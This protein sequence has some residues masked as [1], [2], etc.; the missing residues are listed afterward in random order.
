MSEPEFKML[1]VG[2]PGPLR[3]ALSSLLATIGRFAHPLTAD[4]GLLAL[5]MVREIHPTCV[6]LAS[7]L[8]NSEALE[9]VRQIKQEQPTV[10]LL[11]LADSEQQRR[12]L[13]AVGA[14]R[15]LPTGVPLSQLSATLREIT[16]SVPPKK[17]VGEK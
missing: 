14:D 10:R 15:V 6:L 16:D 9:L 8:P 3:N 1:L 2:K 7:G 13:F 4:G 5:K 12:Q 17:M 11:A